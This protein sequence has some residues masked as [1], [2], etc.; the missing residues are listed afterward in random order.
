MF[1]SPGPIAVEIG[2]L[3]IRWYGI[4]MAS[5]MGIGLLLA[6]REARRRNVD[7]DELLK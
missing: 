2:P 3:S 4:L 6:Y 7:P 5:A 1:G